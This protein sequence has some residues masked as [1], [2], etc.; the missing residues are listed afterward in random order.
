MLEQIMEEIIQNR[1]LPDSIYHWGELKGGTDSTVGVIGTQVMPEM[2]VVKSNTSERIAAELHFYQIY[3][4]LPLLPNIKYADAE[5][6]Y[7]IYDFI[8]GETRYSRGTKQDLLHK[9]ISLMIKHYVP[10]ESPDDYE[11]VE[12]PKRVEHDIDYSVSV[13]GLILRKRTMFW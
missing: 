10:P 12:D 9:L 3:R 11:W 7:I 13:I 2:Y 1:I 8:P 6:R 5:Y 4:G